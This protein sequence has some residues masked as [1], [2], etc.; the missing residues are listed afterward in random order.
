MFGANDPRLMDS[1]K[2]I[3]NLARGKDESYLK[4]ELD[5]SDLVQ[6]STGR[7]QLHLYRVGYHP[8]DH[9]DSPLVSLPVSHGLINRDNQYDE[10][11]I[12]IDCLTG[13]LT[14]YLNRRD[15]QLHRQGRSS[16]LS[17][18]PAGLAMIL[19]AFPWQQTSVL[20]WMQAKSP[21]PRFC[22]CELPQPQCGFI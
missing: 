12:E 22:H 9:P 1:S 8:D 2:N 16:I 14:I 11:H 19:S 6:S 3:Y 4:L 7:A 5:I 17:S 18:I 21:I 13:V 20:H 15:E 10:H